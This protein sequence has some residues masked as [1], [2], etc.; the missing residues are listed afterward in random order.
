MK[1]IFLLT[2]ICLNF[3]GARA[4]QLIN[5][6]GATF[7]Y[8]LYSKWFSDYRSV[9]SEIQF[10]YQSIGSG[11]GIKQYSDGTVDF[12]A[13]DVPMT[14]AQLASASKKIVHIPTALG[15]VAVTINLS[16]LKELKLTPEALA[17]IFLGK[18]KTWNDAEITKT[19]PGID[20][21]AK[22]I[23]VVHRSDGSGT[24]GIFTDYLSKISPEWKS[25]VGSAA[26]VNWPTGLGGKGNEGVTGVVKQTP[27]AIGYIELLYAKKNNLTT[28]S[29]K[30]KSGQFV[31]P[32][33]SAITAA[34]EGVLK[35]IPSDFRVYITDAPGK[36]AYPI[37]G[38]T[39]L[40][41]AEKMPKATGPAIVD[42][43]KW[44]VKAGQNANET[45]D[46]SRLPQGLVA[47]I[48]TKLAQIKFE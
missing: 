10:N 17:G 23:V 30:N 22:P 47:K 28:V 14:D 6:A 29:L 34:A 8:P 18:I 45:L 44:A 16:P 20:V 3:P 21:P 11:G 43:L 19:N 42:F 25:K 48:E 9:K 39:Y 7:P 24:T 32:T 27:G 46:Y 15:A 2:A 33:L 37:S 40:L 38:F 41:I 12:G 36:A 26:S 31:A 5:G 1:I 35:S 4:A 13:T